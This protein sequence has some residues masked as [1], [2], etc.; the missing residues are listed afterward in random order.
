M[1]LADGKGLSNQQVAT[2]HDELVQLT[3]RLVGEVNVSSKF[4][5]LLLWIDALCASHR[6][7]EQKQRVLV[8]QNVQHDQS[9][10][11]VAGGRL[12]F[13]AYEEI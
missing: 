6:L 7:V 8:V 10:T 5:I 12:G 4:L 9:T 1:Q 3:R 13:Q 2:L 11:T